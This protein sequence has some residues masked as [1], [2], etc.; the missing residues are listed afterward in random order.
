MCLPTSSDGRYWLCGQSISH[1]R[2]GEISSLIELFL[3]VWMWKLWMR[4]IRRLCFAQGCWS[5]LYWDPDPELRPRGFLS[6]WGG[7]GTIETIHQ[8]AQSLGFT[9]EK[10]GGFWVWLLWPGG[11]CQSMPRH[12]P[13]LDKGSIDL[14]RLKFA[15]AFRCSLNDSESRRRTEACSG[16][17]NIIL[18]R[19]S[20]TAQQM[21]AIHLI[22]LRHRKSLVNFGNER[23]FL[24]KCKCFLQILE[25]KRERCN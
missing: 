23:W 1:R 25:L 24:S 16:P 2:K 10:R 22:I 13:S 7:E 19:E 6:G 21:N 4:S 20:G 9:A 5:G 8:V 12:K 14:G 11:L 3:R 17:Q 15:P 18:V